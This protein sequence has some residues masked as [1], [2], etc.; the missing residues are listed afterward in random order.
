MLRKTGKLMR[1]EIK[2]SVDCMTGL[3]KSYMKLGQSME[4]ELRIQPWKFSIKQRKF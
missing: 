1:A 2:I 4:G 3:G